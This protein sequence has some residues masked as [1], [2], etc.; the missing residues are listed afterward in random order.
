MQRLCAV[1]SMVVVGVWGSGVRGDDR[2]EMPLDD[3][4]LIKAAT[5]ENA[6]IE[7]AKLADKHAASPKVKEFANRMAKDHRQNYDKMGEVLKNRKIGVVAGLEK[8]VKA[9][10]DRLGKLNGAEFDREF[11]QCTIK[12][13]KHAIAMFENQAKNGKNEEI[14]TFAKNSLSTLRDHLK[15]AEELAKNP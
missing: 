3:N 7:A 4:F 12:G 11:L 14:R 15:H 5:C 6:E 10:L 2:T 8:D 1:L 9:E 13:H